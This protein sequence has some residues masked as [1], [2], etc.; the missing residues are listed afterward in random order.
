MRVGR[1]A[2]LILSISL[3]IETLLPANGGDR[4]RLSRWLAGGLPFVVAAAL[5][6]PQ[7]SVALPEVLVPF[8]AIILLLIRV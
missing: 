8:V 1:G 4:W 7:F 3:E 6:Y 2:T 5:H